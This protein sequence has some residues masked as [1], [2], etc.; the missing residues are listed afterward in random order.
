MGFG[1]F[2]LKASDSRWAFRVRFQRYSFSH[3]FLLSRSH[4]SYKTLFPLLR[5]VDYS[6]VVLSLAVRLRFGSGVLKP[7]LCVG[8]SALAWA[9]LSPDPT[10]RPSEIP[11]GGDLHGLAVLGHVLHGVWMIPV[12]YWIVEEVDPFTSNRLE[13][14]ALISLFSLTV[15][16]LIL[17]HFGSDRSGAAWSAL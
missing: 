11:V 13:G 10:L 15:L 9:T 3:H 14:S 17:R 4:R 7:S 16:L 1:I 12:L 2:I 5:I 8:I 6:F